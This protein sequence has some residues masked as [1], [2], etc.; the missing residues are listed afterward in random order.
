MLF[1]LVEYFFVDYNRI[2]TA[3]LLYPLLLEVVLIVGG[4]ASTLVGIFLRSFDFLADK[5]FNGQFFGRSVSV[6]LIFESEA[7][8]SL[9]VAF[10]PYTALEAHVLYGVGVE[11][12][13]NI[14]CDGVGVGSLDDLL[15]SLSNLLVLGINDVAFIARRIPFVVL[16]VAVEELGNA[17][18]IL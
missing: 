12:V 7:V 15:C 18:S 10:F 9:I 5:N 2:L 1:N 11:A 14:G 8:N 4:D 3:Q 6:F 17:C 16:L 13:V